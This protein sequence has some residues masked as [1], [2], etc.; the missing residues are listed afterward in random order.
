MLTFV[1]SK[2]LWIMFSC[3]KGVMYRVF[4]EAMLLVFDSPC[5]EFLWYYFLFFLPLFFFL[6]S[7]SQRTD[8]AEFP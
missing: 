6:A 3:E 5:I 8:K 7:S 1:G 2:G 4:R